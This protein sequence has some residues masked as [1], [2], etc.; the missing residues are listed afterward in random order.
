MAIWVLK[1]IVQ[2]GIS[3]LPASH[4]VNY[5]FQKNITKG[6]TLSDDLFEDKLKHCGDHVKALREFGQHQMDFVA[7][8]LGTG[9][10]P[11]VPI[12]LWLCG[13][14]EIFTIDLTPLLRED[15]IQA[16]FKKFASYAAQNRLAAFLPGIIPTRLEKI[17]DGSFNNLSQLGI[18]P[19]NGDARKTDF[20]SGVFDLICSNNVFEHIPREI[21]L[22]ILREFKRVG[23]AGGAMSHFVDMSDHF[24]HLDKSISIYNFLKYSERK[25]K[26]IDN[27]VQPQN[28]MRIYDFRELYKEAGIDISMEINRPGD[29]ALLAQL[30]LAAPYRDYPAELTAI[31]HTLLMSRL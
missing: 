6:V 31:S 3:F 28:R 21:L 26:W 29:T 2:K 18:I 22:P 25:W 9:W 11:I 13:A 8:E 10:F 24:S 30:P 12:G 27:S 5:F 7:L 17:T 4:K 23:K 16:T 14:K 19:V 20:K 15:N 1:A